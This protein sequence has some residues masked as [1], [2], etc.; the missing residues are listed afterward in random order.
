RARR[1]VP[2][3][4]GDFRRYAARHVTPLEKT[5]KRRKE[6]LCDA[7]VAVQPSRNPYSE[8]EKVAK[9]YEEQ[10]PRSVCRRTLQ[11]TLRRSWRLVKPKIAET[12][13]ITDVERGP[14]V[15]QIGQ[16]EIRSEFLGRLNRPASKASQVALQV[17]Q[18]RVCQCCVVIQ[19]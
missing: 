16:Q 10:A 13:V 18:L 19:N 8:T 9:F 15:N 11:E 14:R 6:I 7:A 5:W 12:V 4:A 17:K 1:N 2:R 3:H